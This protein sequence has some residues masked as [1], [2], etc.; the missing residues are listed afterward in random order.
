MNMKKIR[1]LA[2]WVIKDFFYITVAIFVVIYSRWFQLTP[3][4]L[5]GYNDSDEALAFGF[6]L[7]IIYI[8]LGIFLKNYWRYAIL[9]GILFV[10]TFLFLLASVIHIISYFPS[11]ENDIKCNG[12]RYYITWSHPFSDYQWTNDTLAVWK[13]NFSYETSFFGYSGGPYRIVCDEEKGDTNIIRTMNGVLVET[14]GK[15]DRSYDS[16]AKATL[17]NRQYFLATQCNNWSPSI[18]ETVTYTLYEC[19]LEYKS[20]NALPVQYTVNFDV[21]NSTNVFLEADETTNDINLY[22][23]YESNPGRTLIFTY[24]ENPHCYVEG[25]KILEP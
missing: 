14:F 21:Y 8:I 23:G 9:R 18:C 25:C 22:D 17:Q 15:E 24:G 20:C 6:I 5:N 2:S 10:P 4:M 13:S 19:N 16:Y 12:V 3:L 11:L 1:S 7:L